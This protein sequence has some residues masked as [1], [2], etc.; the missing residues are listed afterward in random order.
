MEQND[1]AINNL[2]T[3]NLSTAD[4]EIVREEG[5]KACKRS[6]EYIKQEVSRASE[7]NDLE[8]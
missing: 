5:K 6:Q 3:W 1:N 2:P 4:R 8:L 7:D